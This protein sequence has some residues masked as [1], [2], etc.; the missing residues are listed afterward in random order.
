M[1]SH[2]LASLLTHRAEARHTVRVMA[3]VLAAYGLYA[4]F[5]LPQGYWAV[6]TTLIVMQASIGG[7]VGAS[8]DRMYGTVLGAAVGGGAAALRALGPFGLSPTGLGAALVIATGITAYVAMLRPN[9]KVAPVTA[10][11][12]LLSASGKLGPL[13]A[14]AYRVVE[15]GIGSLIGVAATL[16]IFPAR[17]RQVVA[18]RTGAVL[19]SLAELLGHYA[20]W[21]E[22]AEIEP[23]EALHPLHDRIR[24]EIAAVERAVDDTERE[25]A[26]RLGY[27]HLSPATPRTLWRVRS[28]TLAV[29]RALRTPWPPELRARLSEPGARMLRA[30]A[31]FLEGCRAALQ[32]NATVQ[33]G[34]LAARHDAVQAA[35]T[36]LRRERLTQGFDLETVGATFSFTFA[37]E[38]LYGHL[39]DLADRIDEATLGRPKSRRTSGAGFGG[40]ATEKGGPKA[41]PYPLPPGAVHPPVRGAEVRSKCSDPKDLRLSRSSACEAKAGPPS[42]RHCGKNAESGSL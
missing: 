26:A 19:G 9:M 7:T 3:A 10:A 21:L 4:A 42:K 24:A 29:G 35:V 25:R 16:L 37:L 33:P 11:I 20:D 31:A 32:T 36:D 18:E 6:F 38:S 1:V 8:V 39:G 5:D 13:H 15:I 22:R 34:E 12:M 27:H 41:R 14:A 2:S 17:S 40:G 30:D 23:L 28:E